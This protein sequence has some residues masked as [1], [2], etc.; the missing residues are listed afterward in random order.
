MNKKGRITT[1]TVLYITA[2]TILLFFMFLI[3]VLLPWSNDYLAENSRLA[4]SGEL[5]TVTAFIWIVFGALNG[6]CAL[7]ILRFNRYFFVMSTALTVACFLN[8]IGTFII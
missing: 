5:L 6:I 7:L 1:G 4:T 2:N 8:F 3:P